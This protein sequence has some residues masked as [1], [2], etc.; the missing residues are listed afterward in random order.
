MSI[1]KAY[2]RISLWSKNNGTPAEIE[3]RSATLKPIHKE[4]MFANEN[5]PLEIKLDPGVYVLRAKTPSGETS[6]IIA[7]IRDGEIF[8]HQFY[9][10]SF[11]PHE[12]HE[13]AYVTQPLKGQ[14]AGRLSE[15]RYQGIWMRLW[16]RQNNGEWKV[17]PISIP[18]EIYISHHE[19]GVNYTFQ[20]QPSD[21]LYA[22]QVGGPFVSWK[23]TALPSSYTTKVLIRPAAGPKG[24]V[25][26]LEVIVSS[27]NLQLESLLTLLQEGKTSASS[28][29]VEQA[30]LA[31]RFLF[32]KR[33]DTAAAAI[34]GYFLLK[35]NDLSR[36]QDWANNLANWFKW[37]PDGVII[38][39]WQLI[40]QYRSKTTSSKSLLDQAQY[41]LLQA[42]DRGFPLYTEGLR[43]LREG[44]LFFNQYR[45]G[46][47]EAI[48]RAIKHMGK[49]FD[50]ANWAVTSTS[51]TGIEPALPSR[52]SQRGTPTDKDSLVYIFDVPVREAVRRGAL[53]IGDTFISKPP[54]GQVRITVNKKGQLELSDGRTFRSL[55]ALETELTKSSE[56]TYFDW[57]EVKRIEVKRTEA[58]VQPET[59]NQKLDTLLRQSNKAT[60][61]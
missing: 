2:T 39:A 33:D 11:S 12:D 52:E 10:D 23:I 56:D 3:V 41:R 31:Q 61:N 50:A 22:L 18:K 24:R 5:R 43:L 13:W 16:R 35:V 21:H 8:D 19:D 29:L 26:P 53:R 37:L 47:D 60:T 48:E 44:L 57:Q 49:Y 20:R 6:E 34:G 38:H 40:A 9:L 17:D 32:A 36:L 59:L 58:A 30:R 14:A 45:R 27:E 4:W 28:D 51:F 7:E 46:K 55:E 15:S 1:M 42:I 25:H 54:A